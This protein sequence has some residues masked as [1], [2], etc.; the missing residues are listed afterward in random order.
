MVV[1]DK[2]VYFKGYML[3]LRGKN[4]FVETKESKVV[5]LKDVTGTGIATYRDKGILAFSILLLIASILCFV[6]FIANMISRSGSG[7]FGGVVFSLYPLLCIPSAIMF[8]CYFLNIKTLLEIEFAG[9][10]IAFNVKLYSNA[11]C[12]SF[13][14]NLRIAK[15]KAAERASSMTI[16]AMQSAMS[17][18][19]ANQQNNSS[20]AADELMKYGELLQKGLINESEYAEAKARILGS[21]K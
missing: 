3:N 14:K 8:V 1:S 7:T 4:K 21:S 11:E 20:G 6:G 19:T 12:E 9:G 5:D 15:D 10:C 18:I 16:N 2:R 13:Q 17:N